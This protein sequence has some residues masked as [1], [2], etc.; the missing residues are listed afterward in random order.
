MMT[1]DSECSCWKSLRDEHPSRSYG[2]R[3]TKQQAVTF[4]QG[5]TSI[6]SPAGTVRSG[7]ICIM[8][9]PG[10]N[11]LFED[12]E[13]IQE[14]DALAGEEFPDGLLPLDAARVSVGADLDRLVPQEV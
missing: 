13:L 6:I 5:H 12:H 1:S 10:D 14:V 9:L 11:Y 8:R 7:N 3:S 2:R 4:L